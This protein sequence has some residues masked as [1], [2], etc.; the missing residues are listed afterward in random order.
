MSKTFPINIKS[1]RDQ[2]AQLS[3]I[4]QNRY[5]FSQKEG[6]W[7]TRKHYNIEKHNSVTGEY[8]QT[9]ESKFD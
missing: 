3:R 6:R 2:L 7:K 9:S 4:N 5:L 8:L 1:K